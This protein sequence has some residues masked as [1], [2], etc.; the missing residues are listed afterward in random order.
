[1]LAS[2]VSTGLASKATDLVNKHGHDIG[3][4]ASRGNQFQGMTWSATILT[5]I[6]AVIWT[7]VFTKRLQ[8]T[9]I[10]HVDTNRSERTGQRGKRGQRNERGQQD[11]RGRSAEYQEDDE[12]Y[13]YVEKSARGT[14]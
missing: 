14:G 13:E 12:D 11:G 9:V 2:A 3:L 7:D 1:M 10:W 4:S 6:A 5:F 8:E